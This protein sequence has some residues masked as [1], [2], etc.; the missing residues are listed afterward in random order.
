[1]AAC[2]YCEKTIVLDSNSSD[3]KNEVRKEIKGTAKKEIMYSCPYC[4]KVLGFGFFLGGVV[5]GRP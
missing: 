4:D 3:K 2:P 1:M 5:T